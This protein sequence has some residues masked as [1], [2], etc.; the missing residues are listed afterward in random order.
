MFDHWNFRG[1]L[2]IAINFSW[3]IQSSTLQDCCEKVCE[4]PSLGIQYII[5]SCKNGAEIWG[6]GKAWWFPVWPSI[7]WMWAL[8]SYWDYKSFRSEETWPWTFL[9]LP[10]S[11]QSGSSVQE[12]EEMRTTSEIDVVRKKVL[13]L[14]PE[15]NKQ[16][17]PIPRKLFL[18][19]PNDDWCQK[20]GA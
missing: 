12:T 8:P 13:P 14:F 10:R 2:V 15:Y 4:M 17:V 16:R 5:K 11:Q 1:C 19:F 20:W 9:F 3:L 7:P 6:F 18:V